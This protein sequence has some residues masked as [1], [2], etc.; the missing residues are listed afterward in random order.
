MTARR[1]SG[2]TDVR[3]AL[4]QMREEYWSALEEVR[5]EAP[6]LQGFLVFRLGGESY[7]VPAPVA[8]E[9]LR[10]P[11]IIRVPLLPPTL[12]GIINLR[13]EIVA[14]SDLRPF[15]GISSSRGAGEERLVV[16]RAAGVTSAL[17]VEEIEGLRQI[18]SD[19]IAPLTQG[20][21]GLPREAVKGQVD[22]EAGLLVLLNLDYILGQPDF[23][24][25]HEEE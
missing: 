17:V 2:S 22:Q 13:G 19:R 25:D 16:V 5:E 1:K 20:L 3:E 14:V 8:R 4:R 23:I 10:T 24:V 9:V 12:R 7:G 6:D 18:P 15:L 21:N 11:R